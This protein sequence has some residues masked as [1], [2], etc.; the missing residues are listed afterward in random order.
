MD[1]VVHEATSQSH[2]GARH[3]CR[4]QHGVTL[5]WGLGEDLLNICQ[6]AKVKHLVCLIENNLFNFGQ[7][8][9]ALVSEVKQTTGGSHHNLGTSLELFYLAFVG[10]AAVDGNNLGLTVGG[11]KF[12]VFGNLNTQFTGRHN[13]KH[14]HTGAGVG[15]EPLND[16]QTK[17]EGLTGTGLGLANDVLAA[18]G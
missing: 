5:G 2:D 10:L 17:A 4:E 6:E 12:H 9:Q 18:E 7:A 11:G 8:E 13:Y 15:S 16:G 14:L 3:G 1:G